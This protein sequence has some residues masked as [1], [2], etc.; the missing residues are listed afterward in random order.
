MNAN[1][2]PL[3][4]FLDKAA[5]FVGRRKAFD[6][7]RQQ[8][9]DPQGT[10]ASVILG[11]HNIGKTALL[12]HL[13]RQDDPALV[14][15]YIPLKPLNPSDEGDWLITLALE[16]MH[17]LSRHDISLHRLPRPD[18]VKEETRLWFRDNYL[19]E[20]LRLLTHQRMVW[21]LDDAGQLLEWLREEKLPVDTFNYMLD[22]TRRYP[23]LSIVLALD[24]QHEADLHLF[25]PLV[26]L[27]YVIRLESLSRDEAGE[28]LRQPEQFR[29]NDEALDAVYQ[30]SGGEPRLLQRF[31]Y[32]LYQ[33]WE[34]SPP[35]TFT[36]D[37]IRQLRPTVYAES[38]ADLREIWDS[39]SRNERLVLTAVAQMLYDQPLEPVQAAQIEAWLIES[40]F[41]LDMTAIQAALRSLEY[42][43]II[44]NREGFITIRAGMMQTWLVENAR[45]GR[46]LITNSLTPSQRRRWLG[47]VGIAALLLL[48]IALLL[49]VSQG[50]QTP[51]DNR[52]I[53]P[54]VTLV[55]Q[56]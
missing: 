2:S 32:H 52:S 6:L 28:L 39:L 25:S 36:A 56:P 22:L 9:D 12:R 53:E 31:G 15:V 30:A 29:L 41:P 20:V 26:N 38:S 19:P 8:L 7:L 40:D 55:G 3:N 48:V 50:G 34:T 35:T 13:R 44:R 24:S 10:G 46:S 49:I 5:P 51:V 1:Q 16:M 45:M 18:S 17:A 37:I 21:L 42:N 11:R 54:T 23:A 27:A 4:P 43:E 47:L 33:H 14:D